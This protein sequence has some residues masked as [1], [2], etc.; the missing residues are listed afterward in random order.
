MSYSQSTRLLLLTVKTE[1]IDN[2][3]NEAVTEKF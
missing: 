2:Y 3:G 1:R